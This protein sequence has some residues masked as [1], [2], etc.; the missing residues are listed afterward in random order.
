MTIFLRYILTPLLVL[1]VLVF[2]IY[3]YDLVMV[4]LWPLPYVVGAPL[5]LLLLI[6]LF[7]GYGIGCLRAYCCRKAKPQA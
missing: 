3:N 7:I 1:T 2:T 5:S 4:N 6:A